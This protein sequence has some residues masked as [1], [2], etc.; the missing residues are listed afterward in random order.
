MKRIHKRTLEN[1]LPE[2]PCSR[3]G[4]IP[5][6]QGDLLGLPLQLPPQNLDSSQSL[7]PSAFRF[8]GNVRTPF[9]ISDRS[10]ALIIDWPHTSCLVGR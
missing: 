1:D 10:G 2:F 3:L 8:D 7:S 6:T 5:T 4:C 9:V